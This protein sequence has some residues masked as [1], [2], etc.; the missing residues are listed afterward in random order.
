ME[1]GLDEY[2]GRIGIMGSDYLT[3]TKNSRIGLFNSLPN[4]TFDITGTLGVTGAA[5][6]SSTLAVTGNI[7]ES[8]N[9][10]LTNLD[11]VSLSNRINGKVG[12]TGNESISGTKTFN[13]LVNL[14]SNLIL[15]GSYSSTNKL[16]GKNSSDGVGNIT[17]GSGLNLTS[18]ILTA[19]QVDTTSLSDRINNKV[20]LTGNETVAGNKTFSGNTVMDG[21]VTM[22]S[23]SATPTGL[24]GINASNAIGDVTTV[25]QT[26]LFA[27]GV[28]TNQ[29]TSTG[30]VITIEH[31]LNFTPSMV[32]A[33][34]PLST[35]NIVNV[36]VVDEVYILF[37]VR[38]GATNNVINTQN[39]PAIQWFAVK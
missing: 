19:T 9:N 30:G 5:T 13:N 31:G 36:A 23:T 38:D 35:T 7:T 15:S 37:V 14:S 24:I 25:A 11:T 3:F 1:R 18:D 12:L 2:N 17:V 8:G 20:G 26:G 22:S 21:T 34:L 33:N 28:V 32:F 6:L 29:T 4:Y 39:I 16:L 27:R 10:V